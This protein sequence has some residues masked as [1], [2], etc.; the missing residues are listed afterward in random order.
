MLDVVFHHKKSETVIDTL[1]VLSISIECAFRKLLIQIHKLKFT[2]FHN[3]TNE[4]HDQQI[5][6]HSTLNIIAHVFQFSSSIID[7]CVRL[8]KR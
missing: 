7:E 6:E 8:L 5:I 2:S 3:L 1:T 4:H